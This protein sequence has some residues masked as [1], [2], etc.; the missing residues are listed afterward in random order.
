M[1][2]YAQRLLHLASYLAEI[3]PFMPGLWAVMQE[4][5]LVDYLAYDYLSEYIATGIIGG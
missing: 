4:L 5:R 3:D 2:P 1:T